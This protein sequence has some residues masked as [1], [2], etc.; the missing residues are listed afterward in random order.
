MFYQADNYITMEYRIKKQ[1]IFDFIRKIGSYME[2]VMDISVIAPVFNEEKNIVKLVEI[3]EKVLSENFN[4]Y[5]I[6]L[7]NDGSTDKSWEILE[8]LSNSNVKVFHF[9]KNCGQTAGLAAGFEKSSGDVVVTIDADLQ[10]DPEDIM[11]LYS[12]IEEYDM[13]NGRRKTRE[14]GYTKKISSWIGNTVRNMITGDN[15]RDTGCPLKMFKSEVVKS[16][17]LYEG[18]H[19]FLPTLAKINGYKVVEIPVKHYKRKFGVSK[20]GI[21]N[22]VF[23][24]LRDAFAVRWMKK[25]HLNYKITG[26]SYEK[27]EE[28]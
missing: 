13:I 25:R 2:V 10:T 26:G 8:E 7:I 22:R 23:I 27:S 19:R 15:I 4:T 17:Y 11:L 24:G 20:Y 16:Y 6:L 14:D 5:E 3:L 28:R 21:R 9:E 1:A 18:M 12:Y